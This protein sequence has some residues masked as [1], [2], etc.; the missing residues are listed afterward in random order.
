MGKLSDTKLRGIKPG[1]YISKYTDGD[2]LFLK[3]TPKGGM[4]WQWRIKTPTGET[5][6]TYG[7]YPKVGLA[8]A[9]K[10]HREAQEQRRAG[11]VN[12]NVLKRQAKL[13]AE[14]D[15]TNSFEAVARDWF[16]VRRHDWVDTYSGRLMRRLKL[17]VFPGWASGRSTRSSPRSSSR[18][19]GASKT[20]ELSRLPTA[21]SKAARRFSD[22]PSPWAGP[23]PIPDVT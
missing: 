23:H 5:T 21:H 10:Q 22:T 4:Y 16:E 14:H 12:P 15:A 1:A 7:S 9:R 8:D 20:G 11:V 3:V 19:S 2:G 17:D 6:V 18:L 13:A